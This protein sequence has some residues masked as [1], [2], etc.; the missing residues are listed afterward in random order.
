[1]KYYKRKKIILSK[2]EVDKLISCHEYQ[3]YNHKYWK[4]D[5][6]EY[7]DKTH[8]SLDFFLEQSPMK[9]NHHT[10]TNFETLYKYNNGDFFCICLFLLVKH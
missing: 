7:D 9:Q 10:Y 2:E 3:E 8:H 6:E 5:Y 4:Y 1:M